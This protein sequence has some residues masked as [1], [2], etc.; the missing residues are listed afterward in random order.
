MKRN[1]TP[2]ALI[3]MFA[4]YTIKPNTRKGNQLLVIIAFMFGLLQVNAQYTAIPDANFEAIFSSIDDVLGD[5]QLPTANIEGLTNITIKDSNISDLTGIEDFAALQF[6]DCSGNRITSLDLSN[7]TSLEILWAYNNRLTSVNLQNGNNV[8]LGDVNLRINDQLTC[9]KVDD[10][11]ATSWA[12]VDSQTEFSEIDCGYT[13]IPDANFEAALE[14]LGYDDISGDGQVPTALIESVEEL[15]LGFRNISDLTGI[16]DFK[17]LKTLYCVANELTSLDLSENTN[18]QS[19]DVSSNLL[20]YLDIRN[21]SNTNMPRFY[22]YSNADLTCVF[23]DNTTFSSNNWTNIDSQTQFTDTDYCDY[24]TIPD[25][26]F[27]A[28]LEA[29]GYDD[30]SGDGQVPTA[31][32]ENVTELTVFEQNI[33]DVTGL[34][35]FA[36]LTDLILFDL[37]LSSI[38]VS[39]NTTLESLTLRKNPLTELDVSALANLK[40]LNIQETNITHLDVSANTAL[41]GLDIED[42]DALTTVDIKNGNNTNITSFDATGSENLMCILVDDATYSTNNWTNI[43]SQTQFIDTGYCRYTLIPDAE[44]EAE[45]SIYDDISGD[46]QAPT[47]ILEKITSLDIFEE[48]ITDLTGI[49]DFKALTHLNAFGNRITYLDLSKNTN[50]E[51][52]YLE[53]NRL[54]YLNLKNGANTKIRRLAAVDNNNLSCILVDDAE[55]SENNWRDSRFINDDTSFS[56]TYCRYTTI[57]DSNFEA[58]LEALGYDDIS[59][60]GQVPTAL[61]EDVTS[62]F[63]VE[64]DIQDL[65][66]IE[67]FTSLIELGLVDINLPAIDL[68][69]NDSIE[70]LTLSQNPLTEL[71]L[72]ANTAL[73]ILDLKNSTNLTTLNIRNG[74]NTSITSFDT[75]GTPNLKCILVD[76]ADYSTENWPNVD[77]RSQFTNTNYCEYTLIPDPNFEHELGF[78]GY[79]DISGD[80]QVPTAVIETVETINVSYR[81]DISDLTGIE[82]FTALTGLFC[83]DNKLTSLDLS[84]NTNLERV[85]LRLNNLIYLNIQNGANTKITYFSATE[86]SN[87][88]CIQVDDPEYSANNWNFIGNH[89][90]YSGTYCQYTTIPDANFE[91]VLETLGYDDIPGDGQVPTALI[92]TVIFLDIEGENIAD[93]T[94]IADFTALQI[95]DVGTNNLTSIDLTNNTNLEFVVLDNNALTEVNI[96]NG[97]NTNIKT[98]STIGN[99]DLSCVR[100]DDPVYSADNWDDIDS[101][102]QFSDTAYCG[103]TLVPDLNFE[104]ELEKYGYDDISGDGRVPTELIETVTYLNMTDQNV[105]DL[106]GIEDFSALEFL[107]CQALY[108]TSIDLSNNT[109]LTTVNLKGVQLAQINIKNGA[110]GSITNFSYSNLGTLRTCILVDDAAYSDA[111]WNNAGN[112]IQFSDTSNCNYTLIPDSNFETALE[113][114]GYDN[115]SGDGQVPT[116]LINT[117]TSLNVANKNIADLTGVE[118]FVALVSLACGSNNLT[119]L[120]ISNNTDIEILGIEENSIASIDLSNH[121]ALEYLSAY[122]NSLTSIDLSANTELE[123]AILSGNLLTTLDVTANT[124]LKSLAALNNALTSIDVSTNTGLEGLFID[125]NQLSQVSLTNTTALKEFTCSNNALTSIDLSNNVALETIDLQFNDIED[126][127]LTKNVR[128]KSFYAR[129]NNLKS[130]NVQNGVNTNIIDFDIDTNPDLTCVLVDDELYSTSNWTNIDAQ[131]QFTDANYCDDIA[132]VITLLGVDP[133]VVEFGSTYLDAGASASDN[134]DGDLTTAIVVVNPVDTSVLGDYTIT[135]DVSDTAGNVATQVTRT[136]SIVDTTAPV[137]T[138]LGIDPVVVEF[139]STYLD[140]GA[141][142]S[143]NYDGDLTT[144]IVVVNPVDTLVLGDY[145]ITYNVSDAAGNVATQVTRTVSVVDTTAPVITLLGDNPQTIEKGEAYI[146]LGGTTDDGSAITIDASAVDTNTAGSYTVTYGAADAS[147]NVATPVTRTVNVLES[148][149]IFDLPADNFVIQAVTETCEDKD[150]G[151][152]FINA[153]QELNYIVTVNNESY[154]FSDQLLVSNLA[155]GTYPL[156]I[157]IDGYTDC[158]QCYELVIEEAPVLAGKTTMSTDVESSKVFV[159]IASGTA[160][161]TAMINDEVVGS[162]TTDSFYI[163]VQHGDTLEVLSSVACEGKLSKAIS[164]FDQVT[165]YPNPT[166][167]STTLRI[168]S[169]TQTTITIDVRNALG[170]LVVSKAYSVV[171]GSVV[172]PMDQLSAGIYFLTMSGDL[173]NTLRIV[174]N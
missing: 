95:L 103:Y 34:E 123:S 130:L 26:N 96:Q 100:V 155:P 126:I 66:G 35:D 114:L 41:T 36:A 23:V 18:L 160:P 82:D 87:L 33:T 156:C 45:L 157:A 172:L 40:D 147:G 1:T 93:L 120:D 46:G 168:P 3:Q 163:D 61:I 113:A 68:S 97:T 52:I 122:N 140:A 161:F 47:A 166:T 49:E 4:P 63:I 48:G 14:T 11:D 104:S 56:D 107:L 59:G 78:R 143:D 72:S 136:V 116:D 77:L 151:M 69:N 174:K 44:F 20:T 12:S 106:T 80:G 152:I 112:N 153:A 55:Y 25:G 173:S 158:E 2:F 71:D 54:T 109:N 28:A 171:D 142:A 117:V 37:N 27:E 29:L 79:D 10:L 148:C 164:L 57:P 131:T 9:V 108:L 167:S 92:E 115:I 159:E 134:Y 51:Y 7:N 135:Y 162:Y 38:D 30:I 91:F 62:L 64:N 21:G 73:T 88:T 6:L 101:H 98:F 60:D 94:G 144:A 105:S 89:T 19:L 169:F 85:N 132:P 22:A 121:T 111:N 17:A 15:L 170:V 42:C 137:I 8:N 149:P 127:D 74:N 75:T 154:A 133:V 90:S 139:G 43:E 83:F 146:E 16:E 99:S 67:D 53:E 118:D 138:L 129:E 150:N 86:N 141:S 165:A 50:L 31:L 81:N 39:A 65:T 128:L 58:A 70:I 84:K 5:G 119:S 145:T 102:T 32:I 13:L 110:N 124:K 125:N 24:T 76:D